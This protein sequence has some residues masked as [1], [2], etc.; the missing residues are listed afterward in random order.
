MKFLKER[1][2]A[3]GQRN[4]SPKSRIKGKI[5]KTKNMAHV[6]QYTNIYVTKDTP[7]KTI[8]R[9]LPRKYVNYV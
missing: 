9:T 5:Q 6:T 1:F 7:R 8:S 3:R 2:N 4:S